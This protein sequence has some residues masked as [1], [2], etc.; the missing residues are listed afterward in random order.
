MLQERV[1]DDMRGRTFATLYT[2]VRLCLLLS[3]TIWPF[4][5]GALN[6]LSRHAFDARVAVGRLH[7]ALPGVRLALWLGGIVT[8]LSGIAAQRRMSRL[9]EDAEIVLPTVD[10]RA[11]VDLTDSVDLTQRA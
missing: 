9:D 10:P 5:A 2:I 4:I 3:L 6:A 7:V 11:T 1:A 8:V